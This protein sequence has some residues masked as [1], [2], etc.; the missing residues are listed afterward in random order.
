[1]EQFPCYCTGCNQTYPSLDEWKK[2]H[3]KAFYQL[4]KNSN[5]HSPITVNNCPQIIGF[6]LNEITELRREQKETQSNVTQ[7]ANILSDHVQQNTPFGINVP[8]KMSAETKTINSYCCLMFNRNIVHFDIYYEGDIN[9]FDITKENSEIQI[10]IL[11]PLGQFMT[12]MAEVTVIDNIVLNHSTI[13]CQRQKKLQKEN[14]SLTLYRPI[15]AKLQNVNAK[16]T[17]V[18]FDNN[19]FTHA[20]YGGTGNRFK[21]SVSGFAVCIDVPAPLV[22]DNLVLFCIPISKYLCL[23]KQSWKF[24][25][26]YSDPGCSLQIKKISD[27]DIWTIKANDKKNLFLAEEED[28]TN[29][30]S[31]TTAS[32][33]LTEGSKLNIQM[34]NAKIGAI[35]ILCGNHYLCYNDNLKPV[36]GKEKVDFLVRWNQ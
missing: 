6:L 33:K 17:I 5:K 22:G 29:S 27:E 26:D 24:V 2:E 36:F 28:S 30:V 35:S 18:F 25:D 9:F 11:F 16:P 4:P 19:G 15:T 34:V 13:F 12:T 3:K 23:K 20:E 8:I 7:L 31:D 1:M 32:R 21:I 14:D 10:Q